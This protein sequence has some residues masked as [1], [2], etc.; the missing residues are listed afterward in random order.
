MEWPREVLEAALGRPGKGGGTPG[1]FCALWGRSAAG[2]AGTGPFC[3]AEVLFLF[4]LNPGIC[5][6]FL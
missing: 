3:A 6:I 1:W 5:P 4:F 2:M